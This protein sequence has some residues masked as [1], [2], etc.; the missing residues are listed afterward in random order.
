MR[1]RLPTDPKLQSRIAAVD[2]AHCLARQHYESLFDCDIAADIT[3]ASN[4]PLADKVG[5][6]P[7]EAPGGHSF[8]WR[9]PSDTHLKRVEAN[10]AKLLGGYIQKFGPVNKSDSE[11]TITEISDV[12]K[13]PMHSSDSLRSGHRKIANHRFICRSA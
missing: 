13:A 3:R 9:W 2:P 4:S 10:I 6:M 12:D 5:A 7:V 8:T 11:G 1:Y